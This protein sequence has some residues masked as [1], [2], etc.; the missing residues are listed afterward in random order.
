[1]KK[2]EKASGGLKTRIRD[3]MRSVNKNVMAIALA[4][5]LKGSEGDERRIQRYRELILHQAEGVLCDAETP[6]RRWAVRLKP[7]RELL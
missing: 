6:H 3:R 1:M 2:I 7:L 5:R 4:G